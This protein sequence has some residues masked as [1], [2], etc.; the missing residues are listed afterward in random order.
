MSHKWEIVYHRV[1]EKAL[2]KTRKAPRKGRHEYNIVAIANDYQA[3]LVFGERLNRDAPMHFI[4]TVKL[5][6]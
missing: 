3:A 5:V 6:E 4:H 2:H 1:N